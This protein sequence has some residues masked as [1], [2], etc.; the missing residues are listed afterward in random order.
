MKT[1]NIENCIAPAMHVFHL[2]ALRYFLLLANNPKIGRLR[3]HTVYFRSAA[4]S[5]TRRSLKQ[6]NQK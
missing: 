6:T 2:F 5:E 1:L 4:E 3:C